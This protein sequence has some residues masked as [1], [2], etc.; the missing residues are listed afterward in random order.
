MN[1]VVCGGVRGAA[2]WRPV[3][4]RVVSAAA[5]EEECG[6]LLSLLHSEGT[7]RINNSHRLHAIHLGSLAVAACARTHTHTHTHT[8]TNIN[9]QASFWTKHFVF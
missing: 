4:L 1:M 5:E 9:T 8:H 6:C 3:P 2:E 7:L